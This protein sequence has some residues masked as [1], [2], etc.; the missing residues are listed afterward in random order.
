MGE[1]TL[2]Q[3]Y[4]IARYECL[5]CGSTRD[6]K[7]EY[8]SMGDGFALNMCPEHAEDHDEVLVAGNARYNRLI[9]AH[10]VINEHRYDA[11]LKVKGES[12]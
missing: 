2:D 11:A 5:V 12:E 10:C 7:A 3:A 9:W 4:R 8:F 1:M 6:V